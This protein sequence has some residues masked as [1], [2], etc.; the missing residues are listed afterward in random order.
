MTADAQRRNLLLF[1]VYRFL[2]TSYLFIP[3]LYLQARGLSY[4]QIGLLSSVYCVTVMVFEVPTG[5]LADHFGRRLAMALGS[6][7]MAVGCLVDFWGRS[8]FWFAAGDGLLALGMTLTSGADSAYLF[9]L[10]R[11]AGRVLDYRR[12]EG[13]ATAAKLIGASLALVA[14]GWV[15]RTDIAL[16]YAISAG[17]CFLSACIAAVLEEQKQD[18]ALPAIGQTESRGAAP[19]ERWLLPL[20]HSSLQEVLDRRRLRFAIGFSVL[21]FSLLRQGIYLY[22]IYLKQAHFDVGLI[23]IILAGLNLVAAW[24]AH[25]IE[26]IRAWLGEWWL[27][28]ILPLVMAVTYMLMGTLFTS[29]GVLLLAAQMLVNGIFS[30]LSKELLNREIPNSNQRATVL[31]LE[32]MSRRLVFGIASPLAGFFMDRYGVPMGFWASGVLGVIGGWM[33]FGRWIFASLRGTRLRRKKPLPAMATPPLHPV[34]SGSPP[35]ASSW[36]ANSP[37]R[38]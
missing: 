7:L 5:A 6:L 3:V 10:L 32:S 35:A 2:S 14:G 9:D 22:P 37:R 18:P 34:S 36:P 8:F 21:V 12:L 38:G 17:V 23:G 29:F 31:S 13:S 30:P 33:L 27:I 26:S 19:R 15:A 4:T 1:H 11:D 24:S 16:T 20:I 25:R 28:V